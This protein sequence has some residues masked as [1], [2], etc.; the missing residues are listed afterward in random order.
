MRTFQLSERLHWSLLRFVCSC[1]TS[2]RR[3]NS[4]AFAGCAS[5]CA[6]ADVSRSTSFTRH[7]STWP[8]I[9]GRW[10]G[11][12]GGSGPLRGMA[13][14]GSCG[15][16]RT[17]TTR[18]DGAS[19]RSTGTKNTDLRVLFDERSCIAWSFPTGMPRIS[20]VFLKVQGFP[21]VHISG[22]F[23]GRPFEKDTDELVI[24]A[25]CDH[26]GT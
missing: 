22:G 21:S 2:Q 12:G 8:S 14:A 24:E 19:T 13:P 9:P 10:R 5:I 1:T 3:T 23:D 4:R 15:R 16:R 26:A 25:S 11:C 20:A 18:Y 17:D 6:Q 7:W